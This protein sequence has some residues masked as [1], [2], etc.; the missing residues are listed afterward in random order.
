MCFHH[1]LDF[2]RNCP[3]KTIWQW[4][5]RYRICVS[6]FPILKERND[7]LQ[8]MYRFLEHFC[9]KNVHI[10][11]LIWTF[12][13]SYISIKM[14]QK[15]QSNPFVYWQFHQFDLNKHD[16]PIERKASS[17]IAIASICQ[18]TKTDSSSAGYIDCLYRLF[19]PLM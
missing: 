2:P 13:V 4:C 1:H 5:E 11:Y 7:C 12:I 16:R 10:M 14:E 15:P 6:Y 17:V 18:N 19:S 3:I 8:S 9:F